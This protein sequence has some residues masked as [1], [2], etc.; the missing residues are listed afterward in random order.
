MTLQQMF[1][2]YLPLIDDELKSILRPLHD[3]QFAYYGMMRYHMGW[4]DESFRPAETSAGKR[5]RP[6]LCLLSCQ[7]L[8]GDPK[9]ALA[10]A[11][12][13]ELVHSF[14]LVHDDIEDGSPIRR[15]RRAIWDVWGAPHGINVGDGLFVLARLALHRLAERGVPTHRVMAACLALD[16]ACLALCEGQFLD[17]SFE[18]RHDVDLAQYLL[19]I[20]QKTAALLATS[21]QLGAIVAADELELAAHYRR[22][23]ESLGM[24]FQIQDDVLGAW[25]DEEVTGKSAATDI[26]D[27]K[28]TLPVLYVLERTA[29]SEAAR[30]LAD[31]YARLTPLD[32][33]AVQQAVAILDHEGA[34]EHAERTAATFYEAALAALDATGID[35]AAQAQLRELAASLLGRAT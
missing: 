27:R 28:K 31:L 12:A 23:G 20:R 33:V 16:Q 34:R 8:G 14:S 18:D 26:R 24:A 2:S 29:E 4:V 3:R 6:M 35:N 25:G 9:Q 11:G 21:A 10:A 1:D 19:M 15:G 7:A 30:E 22:F 13:V 17:L 32:E 5:L